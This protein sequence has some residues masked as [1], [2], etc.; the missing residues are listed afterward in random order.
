MAGADQAEYDPLLP[1]GFHDLDLDGRRRLCVERFEQSVTRPRIMSNVEALVAEASQQSIVGEI[2]IDGSLLTEKLNP[3]DAD[4]ALV[5]SSAAFRALSVTQRLFF[6]HFRRAS[7]KASFKIDNY[8]IVI[9][10]SEA[11]DQ[12][13]YAYWLR[14][15]GFSRDNKMKGILRVKLPQRL[16]VR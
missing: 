12:W 11:H 15:F 8:G 9:D 10:P 3:G 2:W 6:D 13:Q 1:V 4:I 7:L 14:Q 16:V 5:I